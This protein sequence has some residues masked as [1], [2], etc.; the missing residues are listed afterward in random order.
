[1]KLIDVLIRWISGKTDEEEKS[2]AR[3]AACVPTY[4]IEPVTVKRMKR[5]IQ[6]QG[7]ESGIQ[8]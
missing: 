8:Q 6:K 1:M 5:R 7:A 4:Q 3:A 2:H